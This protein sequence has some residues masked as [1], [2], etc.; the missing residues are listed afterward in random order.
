MAVRGRGCSLSW[1]PIP[2]RTSV[3]SKTRTFC[4]GGG[5]WESGA[6]ADTM[7]DEDVLGRG[8][9]DESRTLP[10]PCSRFLSTGGLSCDRQSAVRDR[11]Q[12]PPARGAARA[13]N[14]GNGRLPGGGAVRESTRQPAPALSFQ[15]GMNSRA[16]RWTPS[17]RR[18][19]LRVPASRG[20]NRCQTDTDNARQE[21]A[22]RARM[23]SADIAWPCS[24]SWRRRTGS[25]AVH[26]SVRLVP[27]SSA[28]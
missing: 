3:P 20:G 24:R 21:R 18:R 10:G 1:P 12:R 27:E 17:P 28:D 2:Q 13:G 26:R 14:P 5:L 23:C 16:W 9:P 11:A 4:L 15:S 22:V 6:E 19:N 7:S 8:P 25:R